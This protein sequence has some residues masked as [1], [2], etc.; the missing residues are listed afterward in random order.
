MPEAVGQIGDFV[1]DDR[2]SPVAYYESLTGRADDAARRAG[3]KVDRFYRVAGFTLRFRFAGPAL[4]PRLSPAL[5]HLSSDPVDDPDLTVSLWDSVST[6]TAMLPPP[7][8]PDELRVN[9][10]ITSFM[11]AG[12]YTHY[13]VYHNALTIFDAAGRNAIYWI[14]DAEAVPDHETCSPLFTLFHAWLSSRGRFH[15]H[16]GGVGFP[17]GG[18]LLVGQCGSGKS[19]TGLACLD[20]P[21]FYAG[22]DRCI[23]AADPEP[24]VYSIYSTAKTHPEDL[25]RLTF[26]RRRKEELFYLQNG[27]LLY[28][29]DA[30]FPGRMIEGFPLKVILMP[31]VSGKRDTTFERGSPAA[32]LLA[33]APDTSIRWP[34]AG[35]STLR[36]LSALFRTVPVY[37]LNVGTEVGQIPAV[38]QE[39]LGRA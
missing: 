9:G 37:Q 19:N 12:L 22:D 11:D 21:L 38:I 16:A 13:N 15:V 31:R 8:K 25:E 2:L 35:L 1:A 24:W 17:D 30:L 32:G 23:V 14:K 39:I 27:K 7:W 34:S 20:S 6:A 10:E 29:L 18:A 28:F 33:L 26:L 4:V 5:A 3:G 36:N